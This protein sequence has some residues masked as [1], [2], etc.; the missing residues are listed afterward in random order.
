[1]NMKEIAQLAGVTAATV[2][3]AINGTGSV[4]EK[5]RK[6]IMQIIE[7]EG[8]SP[9]RIAKSLRTKESNTIGIMVEDITAFQTPRIIDGVNNYVEKQGYAVILNNMGL[10]EKTG[11]HY[12]ELTS[13]HS[14]ISK[15]IKLFN[16]TQIDGLIYV[17]MHDRDVMELIPK[18]NMPIVLVYC[19]DTSKRNYHVTYD[20]VD[21]I[22]DVAEYLMKHGHERI[23]VIKG[24]EDSLPSQ[25][26]LRSFISQLEKAGKELK[27]EYIFPGAWEVKDGVS[28]YERYKQLKEKPTAIFAMNDLMAVGFMD[29]AL[30]DG[31]RIPEDVSVIGFDNRQECRFTRPRLTTVDIPLEKM[32]EKA[33]QILLRLISGRYLM[34][35]KLSCHVNSWKEIQLL[36]MSRRMYYAKENF[37]NNDVCSNGNGI[38]G[39]MWKQQYPEYNKIYRGSPSRDSQSFRN[40]TCDWSRIRFA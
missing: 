7:R 33:G 30:N 6:E 36:I 4:S 5:K 20:N 26:R 38:V 32:G 3:N 15:S 23:G 1:M 18:L 25:K 29:A 8:Y 34:K 13:Y 10:L 19:Y 39:R 22:T 37:K 9:N 31:V 12:S 35:K 27:E 11:N 17:A 28:A 16:K 21:I 24:A 2:S 14:A 40:E